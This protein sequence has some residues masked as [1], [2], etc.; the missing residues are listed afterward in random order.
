MTVPPALLKGDEL[1]EHDAGAPYD[2]SRDISK[3]LLMHYAEAADVFDRGRHPLTMAHGYCQRLS[4]LLRDCAART[5]TAVDRA[6][7][8]GCSVGGLTHALGTWVAG[9]VVGVDI[10]RRSIEVAQSLTE[11]GGGTFCVIEQGPFYREVAIR[12]AEPPLRCRVRFEVGDADALAPGG[13]P[14]D[15]VV[16][17]NVLDRV[18]RPA[19]CLARFAG[20]A[21]L[22]RPG[23]LL[24]VACPWSW[25]A[26]F[27]DPAQWLGAAATGTPS[28]ESL[29][30]LLAA[31]FDLLAEADEPGVLRQNPREYDYFES[32]VTVWR[33]R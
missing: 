27:S 31:D 22:L 12:V 30:A 3:Y 2:A 8:V 21:E 14:Y 24:M 10:S 25:Y 11:H 6:L 13:G 28:E 18:R 5:G 19:D 32:H 7:D 26:E 1:F 20:P 33:K 16:L 17:S 29:K 4:D 23:G 15:A 9:E